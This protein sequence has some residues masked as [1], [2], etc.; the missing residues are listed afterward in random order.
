MQTT[1]TLLVCAPTTADR[2]HATEHTN[3]SQSYCQQ[4]AQQC[5]YLNSWLIQS[6]SRHLIPTLKDGLS[7]KT[8]KDKQNKFYLMGCHTTKEMDLKSLCEHYGTWKFS[9][10]WVQQIKKVQYI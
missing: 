9:C 2:Q 10:L 3:V 4:Y 8:Y 6:A 5:A 1:L 7:P